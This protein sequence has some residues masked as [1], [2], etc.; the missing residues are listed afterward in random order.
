MTFWNYFAMNITHKLGL[1]YRELANGRMEKY[2]E[3]QLQQMVL[4]P[5]MREL[6]KAA[7]IIP[8]N[9][10]SDEAIKTDFLVQDEVEIVP[11]QPA[12]VD[13]GF[14]IGGGTRAK[15]T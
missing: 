6:S 12:V 3:A 2:N 7:C 8:N 5:L 11:D 4:N 14:V 13:P 1:T 10:I 9:I 15:C